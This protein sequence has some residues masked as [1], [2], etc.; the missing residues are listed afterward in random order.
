MYATPPFATDGDHSGNQAPSHLNA[1]ILRG[2][3]RGSTLREGS[4]VLTY[5]IA[6]GARSVRVSQENDRARRWKSSVRSRIS[7][8]PID[9][10][11]AFHSHLHASRRSER[12]GRELITVL[13]ASQFTSLLIQATRYFR[14]RR[15]RLLRLSS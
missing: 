9:Q 1:K 11:Q 13:H 15:I 3:E 5:A 14:D 7:S 8:S 2:V 6:P 4:Y 10:R 12:Y